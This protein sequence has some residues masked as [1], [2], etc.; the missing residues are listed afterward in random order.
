MS[1][2][3]LLTA[4]HPIP[5]QERRTSDHLHLQSLP[6]AARDARSF[7]RDRAPALADDQLQVLL[8]LTS[9]LVTNAVL[10]A[11]TAFVLGITTSDTAVLVTVGDRAP[12][13]PRMP[14]PSHG[15]ESGRGI[16]L[17]GELAD[18]WGVLFEPDSQGKCVW[19][20][21]RRPPQATLENGSRRTGAV[22]AGRDRKEGGRG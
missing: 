7:I 14:D 17:V 2:E 5:R 19:F 20:L 11:R 8:V 22:S 15:R 12:G 6:T 16:L 3:L 9:E 4:D 21:L 13:R 18:D 10:H 1:C